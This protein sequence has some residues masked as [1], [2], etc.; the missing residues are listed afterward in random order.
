MDG[1]SFAGVAA[2]GN[3]V[4]I[5]TPSAIYEL[6]AFEARNHVFNGKVMVG[7]GV[8][9]HFSA[10]VKYLDLS[11]I[12]DSMRI[13]TDSS[14]RLC[15]RILSNRIE[16]FANLR[17]EA[18]CIY[19]SYVKIM[20]NRIENFNKE[21]DRDFLLSWINLNYSEGIDLIDKIVKEYENFKTLY[22]DDNER[23][24]IVTEYVNFFID[25]KLI[26]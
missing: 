2:S 8:K 25:K 9:S 1:H 20:R 3:I 14:L 22:P 16:K 4:C 10:N 13:P 17:D 23:T 24:K 15:Q 26:E 19:N 21:K 7:Y 5:Y 18:R 12:T 11:L 6:S